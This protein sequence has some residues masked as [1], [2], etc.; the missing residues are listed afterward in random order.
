MGSHVGGELATQR[1][2]ADA[3]FAGNRDEGSVR[4]SC[5]VVRG[6]QLL[7]LGLTPHKNAT[8]Q[9]GPWIR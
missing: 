9:R 8:V 3:W 5:L 6:A 2:L 7:K 4:G 1:G